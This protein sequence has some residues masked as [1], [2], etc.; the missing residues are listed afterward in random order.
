M[1]TTNNDIKI[2]QQKISLYED[3]KAYE[4]LYGFL[5]PQLKNFCFSFVK[6]HEAAEEIVSDVFIK[7]WQIRNKLP[8]I[9]NLK[10]YLYTIAKNFCLNYIA[11]NFKNPV[12]RLDEMD[13]EPCVGLGNP[14][15]LCVAADTIRKIQLCIRA[16][17]PQ[18]RI[19]FQLVKEDGM[20]YKE[21]AE[22]LN[23]S[24]LTV[25]NQVFIAT[26]K[27]AAF[28]PPSIHAKMGQI[29]RRSAS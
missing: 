17:P 24:I 16:L 25:R 6:S 23:I 5:S 19:I 29:S 14:E 3:M 12:I 4:T 18:C 26:R 21:T 20:S 13:F 22:I 10:V 7:L 2:L 1:T 9:E 28:I 27:I 8:D 11:R 15:D